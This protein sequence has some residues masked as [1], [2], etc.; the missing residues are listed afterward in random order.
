[1]AVFIAAL[2]FPIGVAPAQAQ[3]DWWDVL[4]NTPERLIGLLDL[5]DIVQG[6]CGSAAGRATARVFGTPSENGPSIG[7]LYWHEVPNVECD[8]MIERAGGVKELVP[9]LESGYDIPAAI[10]FEQ[11]GSWFRIRLAKG[12]AWIRRD[13]RDFL[14][15][16]DTVRE[17]LS[18]V[19]YEWDGILRETPRA[20]GRVVPLTAGWK[21]LLNCA[22]GIKILDQRR[23]G[24]EIWLHI[25]LITDARCGDPLEGLTPVSGWI[26]AYKPNRAPTVWFSSRGC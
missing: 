10:V 26:P 9:T 11:R 13:V 20:S 14:P 16:P 21:E 17:R 18:Y 15:Y 5:E 12:S 2:F 23:I 25:E 8:L 7:T 1:M 22:P 3:T 24:R 6:G 19:S 4:N